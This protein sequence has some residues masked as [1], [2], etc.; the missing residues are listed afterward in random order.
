MTIKSYG[1]MMVIGFLVAIYII[2]RLSR[3]ITPDP[4]MI[5]NAALYSLIAGVVGARVFY[6]I[7][8][9]DKFKDRLIDVFAIWQGGL[10]LLGGVGEIEDE[11]TPK[12]HR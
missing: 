3:D 2:R 7:H 1:T 6:V 10:E 11:Y 8:Y 9:Y 4:Q 5:T 12:G